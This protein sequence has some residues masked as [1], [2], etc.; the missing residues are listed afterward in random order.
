MVRFS[1]LARALAL[2]SIGSGRVM[3]IA[4]VVLIA[5]T[6]Y[7]TVSN[8]TDVSRQ[9]NAPQHLAKHLAVHIAASQHSPYA[10]TSIRPILQQPGQP[11]CTRSLSHIMRVD[12]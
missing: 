11:D 5:I 6:S 10:L 2:S 1:F 8:M 7:L 3:E 4:L 12:K 9:S